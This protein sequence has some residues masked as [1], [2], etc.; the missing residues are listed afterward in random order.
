VKLHGV[1]YVFIYQVPPPI[2]QPMQATF[3][4]AIALHGYEGDPSEIRSKG[5]FTVK[6]QWQR[7]LTAPVD[8]PADAFLFL[9]LLDAQ[10]TMVAQAE[11]PVKQLTSTNLWQ[12]GSEN[13]S[14]PLAVPTNLSPGPYWLTLG[15]F[16]A[17][18]AMRL[19]L[20]AAYSLPSA[21]PKD[22]ENALP[23]GPFTFEEERDAHLP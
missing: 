11:I 9:H 22:G 12:R 23:L 16:H 5:L 2:A 14:Y 17:P 21:G 7:P 8:L 4:Q 3:G 1:P 18:D 13:A 10:G 19:P 20:L 6:L 15:F